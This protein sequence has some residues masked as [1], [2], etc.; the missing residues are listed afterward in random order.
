[1]R[2]PTLEGVIRRRLLVNYRVD[3]DI[4]ARQ[5]PAPFRPKLQRGTAVAGI[6]L[7]RLEHIHPTVLPIHVGFASE[8]AA[9]RVAVLWND[10]DG[11]HEGVFIP[12]RDTSSWLNHVAGGR[13]FPGEHH[14]ATFAITALDDSIDLFMRSHDGAVTV[15]LRGRAAKALPSDSAFATVLEAS[16][17]F[18]P[19]SLGY[20][21][22]REPHKLHGVR[23]ETQQWLVE[24]LQIDEVASSY[25]DDGDRFPAGTVRFDSALIMRDI[26]HRWHAADELYTLPPA[27]PSR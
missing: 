2:L 12:R 21:V 25:F 7:I 14:R 18:E 8:N 16:N 23:L 11:D 1:M 22:T 15:K 10:A 13:L 3:P 5:L 17:F 27:A 26:P 4:I 20:S 9:H 6:C 24:P 19:G